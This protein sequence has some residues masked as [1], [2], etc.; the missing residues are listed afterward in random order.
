[1]KNPKHK[2]FIIVAILVGALLSFALLLRFVPKSASKT[3]AAVTEAAP[4]ATNLEEHVQDEQKSVRPAKPGEPVELTIP[5]IDVKAA[6]DYVGMNAEGLMDITQ[7]PETVAWYQPGTRPGGIGSAVIAGHYGTWK[8]GQG[9]VFDHLQD[10]RKGDKVYVTDDDGNKLS[11]VVR[12]SRRFAPDA[13][14]TEVFTSDDGK[15]HLNLI[16]CEGT[17]NDAS[18]AFSKRLVVFTDQE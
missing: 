5:A 13:D 11:F 2:L 15:A 14:A 10:L 16:T 4:Q 6:V 17:W 3:G 9:S 18:Q 12:E 7:N 8:S 1:M